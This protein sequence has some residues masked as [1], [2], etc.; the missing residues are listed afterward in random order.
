MSTECPRCA[1]E[2]HAR[3]ARVGASVGLLGTILFGV[4]LSCVYLLDG[5]D[6][7]GTPSRFAPSAYALPV[8]WLMLLVAGA[9]GLFQAASRLSDRAAVPLPAPEHLLLAPYRPAPTIGCP[10]HP[11]ATRGAPIASLVLPPRTSRSIVLGEPPPPMA[12]GRHDAIAFAIIA[13]VLLVPVLAC[14]V[15]SLL[16]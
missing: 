8:A 13:G 10:R 7:Y 9:L 15:A 3:L 2:R 6:R 5:F 4:C 12:S 16:F 11:W 14:L 1:A